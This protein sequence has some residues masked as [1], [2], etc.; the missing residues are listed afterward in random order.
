[1][2][3]VTDLITE[4]KI[5]SWKQ[6][7]VI[8]ITA[9]T[10]RGK[11]HW[12]KNSIYQ[13]ARNNGTKI[14]MLIHRTSCVEQFQA[15][16]ER[17]NKSD[18]IELMTYQKL[19]YIIR[20]YGDFDFSPYEYI[21]ADEFHYWIS[22][23]C[24]MN[25]YLDMSLNKILE[26]TD[27]TRIFMSA[28]GEHVQRYINIRKGLESI[29]YEL[30]IAYD[31]IDEL[32]FFNSDKRL[33]KFI[34]GAIEN[35]FKSIFF[36]DSATKAYELHKKFK[37][38]TLFNCSKNDKHYKYVDK[39]KINKMLKE[40]RFDD[41]ILITTCTMST[42]VNIIDE[43]LTH[44]VTDVQDVNTLIQC[45]GR[46]RPQ[47]EDDKI[48]LHVKTITNQQLGGKYTQF[49]KKAEM[50][51]YLRKEGVNKYIQ[52]YGRENDKYHI[53]YDDIAEDGRPTKKVN[54]LILFKFKIDM[55]EIEIMKSRGD[56]G[57]C[58]YL[59]ELLSF[60]DDTFGYQYGV[61]DRVE[62][63]NT[64]E[65]YLDSIAG[66]KLLK[67]DQK[68]LIEKVSLKDKRGRIQKGINIL[69]TYFSENKMSYMIVSKQSS[70]LID[71]KKKNYRYW[72]V[73]NNISIDN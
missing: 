12:I 63:K 62:M 2:K 21:C 9:G 10:G 45:V 35:N 14:L 5:N 31:F 15:E 61:V 36:I 43:E 64:L 3:R 16:I 52:M 4:E 70:K 33:E 18:V 67:E 22:P 69:N 34:E 23:D 37:D 71:G 56:F 51:D 28:T 26:Q 24:T 49:K 55:A 65:E 46:K 72:E 54:E 38:H 27:K 17:D 32:W 68:E 29:N 41:L 40:E 58:K 6:G 25:R 57:Y 19:E 7:E 60:Y 8:V 20:K 30:P 44:I 48:K 59:A 39:D 66:K 47:H 13:K 1:M 42:G 73:L 53:V 11:S 50:G